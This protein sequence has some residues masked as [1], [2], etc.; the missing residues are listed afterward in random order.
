MRPELKSVT[1][2]YKTPR[3]LD[4]RITLHDYDGRKSGVSSSFNSTQVEGVDLAALFHWL[5]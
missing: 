4:R 3:V 2:T 1:R 5:P